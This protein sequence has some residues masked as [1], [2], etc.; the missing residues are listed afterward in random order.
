MKSRV[1]H[2]LPGRLRLV[3]RGLTYLYEQRSEIA[4]ELSAIPG[5]LSA[6]VTPVTGGVLMTYDKFMLESGELTELPLPAP[7]PTREVGF[8]YGAT[9]QKNPALLD[10]LK[11]CRS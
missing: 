1:A 2:S 6:R 8:L 10:F 3:S 9:E 4:Q 11:F 7:V 5:V